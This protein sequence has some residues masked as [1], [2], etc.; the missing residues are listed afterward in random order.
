MK[1]R[2]PLPLLMWLL[3]SG[4]VFLAGCPALG[5]EYQRP[6]TGVD[7]PERFAMAVAAPDRTYAPEQ[8]WREFDD[9]ALNRV[10]EGVLTGNPDI[11]QAAASVLEARAL[12][13]QARAERFPTLGLEAG[14]ARQGQGFV[15]PFT[16]D[17]GTVESEVY[18]LA[19]P[20]SF[21]LDLWGRLTRASQAARA[22]LLAAE[23][24]CRTITHSLVAEA[25][26]Q[27]FRVRSLEARLDLR[28]RLARTY[29]DNRELVAERYRRGLATVLDVRQA[30]RILAQAE[31]EIPVVEE[32]LGRARQALE[33]LQGKY[34]RAAPASPLTND[35]FSLPPPIP[36]GLP[37]DL[38]NRRPDIRAA[39][40]SLASACARI[41][42]AK[43]NRFPRISLTG[44]FGYT[45]D[46]LDLL[47][48]PESELWKIGAGLVQPLFDAGRRK[49]VQRAAEARYQQQLAQ[50]ARTVLTAL[51]EVEGALLTREQQL[52]RRRRLVAY[53]TEAQATLE[54][55]R[56]RYERGL[57]SY[58]HVLD[59][60]QAAFQAELSLV[61]TQYTIYTNRVALYRALGGGWD[62]ASAMAAE[63]GRKSHDIEQPGNQTGE[64]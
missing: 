27:Y 34:P 2:W 47:L 11:E 6:D 48:K 33:V 42:V 4:L 59:A 37:A 45:S 46:E 18:S 3:L 50:Y 24:N 43:A 22:D 13:G 51:A 57:S 23:A 25:V 52:E 62:A 7:L 19:L 29:R 44:E 39:E 58:L 40:A 49:A 31:A 16:G 1:K 12:A 36:A 9:P 56:D 35:R 61:E 54:S 53:F 14:A 32:A 60:Q 10:V 30:R 55:A 63:S 5:P 41:G 8:W 28:Q 26:S 20:A 64:Q 17:T 21:E 15:D 38:L